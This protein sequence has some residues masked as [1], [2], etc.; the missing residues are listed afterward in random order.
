MSDKQNFPWL[1]TARSL[2]GLKEIK[3]PQHDPEILQMWKNIKRGG[4]KDDET[5][6]CAAFVGSCLE[7][8]GIRSTRFESAASYATWGQ[9]LSEP[10]YGCIAVG[11]RSG[12][13][14]VGF[15]V[16]MT[17]DGDLLLLGGNQSDSVSIV[18]YPRARVYAYRWPSEKP[19][20]A[21]EMPI[22]QA[23]LSV[24]ED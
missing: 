9:A 14:H 23:A 10:V 12:G 6:W 3:G 24:K 4:I 11:K 16:G 18:R 13:G 2:I 19:L 17:E 22:G 21:A 1:V 20:Y 7:L 5:P 8:N 15:V